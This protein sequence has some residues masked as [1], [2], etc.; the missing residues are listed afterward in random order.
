MIRLTRLGI[1][2]ELNSRLAALTQQVADRDDAD[3]LNGARQLW[4][5]SAQRRNVH[6]PLTDVLRQMAPGMERCMYC[7][8]SQGTAIDHHEPMARN[9]LRTFDWLNHLLS[10]TYCN[11]HEKRDR[12]PLD[13]NGQP[14]LI[15]PST[16]DPFDH[17]QLTLTLGVYRA[18]GGSPK[19]QTTIDVC[20]LNRPILTKGRVALLSRPE[21]REE[22]LR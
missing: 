15:D 22:L 7:G 5:H 4:K 20:G 11:S 9:P 1:P 13:R 19:G 17:L 21:L 3:R 10:C 2:D 14:L 16:E 6:R 12:F 8:D 18:K